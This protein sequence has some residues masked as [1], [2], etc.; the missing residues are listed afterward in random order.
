MLHCYSDR[1]ALGCGSVRGGSLRDLTISERAVSSFHP[2]STFG[3]RYECLSL[4]PNGRKQA[5][6]VAVKR[7]RRTLQV[8]SAEVKTAH[9]LLHFSPI[10]RK[11]FLLEG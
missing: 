2:K 3:N 9:C 8:S 10:I 7:L 5:E 6:N 11:S 4:W 1:N